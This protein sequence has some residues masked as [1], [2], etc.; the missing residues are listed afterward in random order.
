MREYGLAGMQAFSDA[1]NFRGLERRRRRWNL[2]HPQINLLPALI[3]Q[4][5]GQ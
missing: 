1:A 5:V 4:S 3:G 2:R